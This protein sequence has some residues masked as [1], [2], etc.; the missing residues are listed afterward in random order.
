MQQLVLKI[1]NIRAD[2]RWYVQT[3]FLHHFFQGIGVALFFTLAN[4]LFLSNYP[5]ESL[6]EVYLFAAVLLLVVG[7]IYA[8]FEHHSSIDR[9]LPGVVLVLAGSVVVLRLTIGV[10]DPI[11]MPFLLLVW[12]HA[13]YLLGS[14]EFW[15]LS[16]LLFDVRQSKRLFGLISAG[17]IPAKLLG[18]LSVSLLVPV[19][20]LENLAWVAGASFLVS[21]FFLKRLLQNKQLH[22]NEAGH[23]AHHHETHA[24]TGTKKTTGFQGLLRRFFGNDFILSLAGVSLMAVLVLTFIDFAF[25][26]EVKYRYKDET[27]LASFLGFFF[28]VGKG[29][30]I[31]TKVFFSGRLIDRLGAKRAL[32]IL[33]VLL[34]ILVG[35][36]LAFN[37][38][39]YSHTKLLILFG[40]MTLV[41]DILQ[42][43]L[44]DPVFLALFQPLNEHLRL[45]GHTVIKGVV[46]P[47]GLG[48]AGLVLTLLYALYDHVDLSGLSA[49]LLL[50]LAG[51]IAMVFVANRKYLDVLR[52]AVRKHYLQGNQLSIQDQ[53]TIHLLSDKLRS[54]Y[55]EEVLYAMEL[56]EKTDRS[57]FE[58]ALPSLLTHE[59]ETIQRHALKRVEELVI[60]SM[61]KE[62]LKLAHQGPS[63]PVRADALRAYCRLDEEEALDQIQAYLQSEE[64]LLH[65]SAITGL[66]QTGGIEATVFAGQELLRLVASDR[67]SDKTL[68]ADI[69][70]DLQ[71]KRFYQP[72]VGFLQ[73]PSPRVQQSALR[74][75]GKVANPQLLPYLKPYLE[76]RDHLSLAIQSLVGFQERAIAW[77]ND[78]L[79][80]GEI[81]P[82][83]LL[84]F[85]RMAR[86]IGGPE[87]V[88]LLLRLMDYPQANV[89]RRSIGA[90]KT[91]DARLDAAQ[92]SRVGEQLEREI[93]FAFELFQVQY[94]LSRLDSKRIHFR[95]PA[96]IEEE[97]QLSKQR[98]YEL[99]C[100][101][102]EN[103]L[104][105][106][107]EEG[108]L[109][110]ARR[111]P[112]AL[113][114]LDNLLSN[115]WSDRL[116]VIFDR[117]SQEDRLQRVRS[118]Q[119]PGPAMEQDPLRRIIRRGAAYY[120]PWTLA[121]ALESSA[122]SSGR[123][124][125]EWVA[126]Y[127]QSEALVVRQAA[128]HA[129]QAASTLVSEA[130]SSSTS[131]AHSS[132]NM[133]VLESASNSLT[134]LEKVLILKGTPMFAETPE[135][136]LVDLASIVQEERVPEAS[137]IFNK[138]DEGYCMYI[139]YEGSVKI[140]DGQVEFARFGRKDFF[141]ELSLLDPEPR[142]A[143]ATALDECFLLRLDQ[144]P[145]YELM[146]DRS[147]VARGILAVLCRRLRKQNQ[148]LA[149]QR[150]A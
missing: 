109:R 44:H 141:G 127:Q 149:A 112:N 56:L 120:D 3:L 131:S 46:N 119:G 74:A 13:I 93:G 86:L 70:G 106:E 5:I 91:L 102:F 123:I 130:P 115:K 39:P 1:L 4:A 31:V 29:I 99:V 58:T 63:I 54:P 95:L 36:L 113:E 97:L 20:G 53:S 107:V 10:F 7:R 98:L 139:I 14:L 49:G 88:D 121:L 45:Q 27:E 2:E 116:M 82:E 80:S 71:I 78:Q 28:S 25:L 52:Y 38:L 76:Q 55:P 75:S 60:R 34:L 73:D 57:R 65:R 72:L 117:W 66:L 126:A 43:A 147:E 68:A 136:V 11:W 138:G 104:L 85:V 148:M 50:P 96:A 62:V 103:Q 145:F 128:Q 142:S 6:A 26:S 143:S 41:G 108:L 37:F 146:N 132:T 35:A 92:E 87:S 111:L 124:P 122:P 84:R 135:H 16:A 61:K 100:L 15:G 21:L 18:Y 105:T 90:L 32:L 101:F 133:Q 118:F 51:W 59:R 114:I 67:E 140:H 24:H 42:Y 22:E 47:V 69:I 94:Q 30:T 79:Q 144:Q 64:P 17:D 89:R 125:S 137:C 81:T 150:N 83:P 12:Y 33:P 134:E 48:I 77:M 19:I 110:D 40:L 8:Y 129:I 23:H 9:L